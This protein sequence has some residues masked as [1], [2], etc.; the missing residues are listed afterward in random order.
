MNK[1]KLTHARMTTGYCPIFYCLVCHRYIDWEC[2]IRF[3]AIVQL[4]K[5]EIFNS[6]YIRHNYDTDDY[7]Y[8]EIFTV[9]RDIFDKQ[10]EEA[11]EILN[12][13][14]YEDITKE[15][16]LRIQQSGEIMIGNKTHKS[17]HPY[18]ILQEKGIRLSYSDF[19]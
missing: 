18:I 5:E 15:D 3:N 19:K 10:N 2:F 16:I 17:N 1:Y 11:E 9:G 7:G 8:N 12:M 6:Q 4:N 14:W 13:D